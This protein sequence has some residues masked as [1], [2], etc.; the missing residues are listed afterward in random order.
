M[1]AGWHLVLEPR[2]VRRHP[3]P[4]ACHAVLEAPHTRGCSRISSQGPSEVSCL[5]DDEDWLGGSEPEL[6]VEGTS[7]RGDPVQAVRAVEESRLRAGSGLA[8][9]VRASRIEELGGGHLME[10]RA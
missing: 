10:T 4:R 9:D 5:G 1:G 6:A 8:W 2:G 7:R 3:R